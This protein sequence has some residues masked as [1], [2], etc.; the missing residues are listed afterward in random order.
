MTT[1]MDYLSKGDQKRQDFYNRLIREGYVFMGNCDK[2]KVKDRIKE[3]SANN[4]SV[5][6]GDEAWIYNGELSENMSSIFIK[7]QKNTNIKNNRYNG[8]HLFD[9][10]FS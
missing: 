3:Y 1:L 9:E 5:I 2:E 6:I 10:C 4:Y 8:I 7:K